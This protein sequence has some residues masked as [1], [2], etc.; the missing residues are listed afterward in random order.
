MKMIEKIID[1]IH[2]ELDGA[3]EYAEKYIENKAKGNT[4]RAGIYK[5]MANDELRHAERIHEFGTRDLEDIQ[6][7]YTLSVEDTEKWEHC[8]KHFAEKIALIRHMLT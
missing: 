7:V 2:E 5:E 6:R 3:K 1:H 4:V 8:Q